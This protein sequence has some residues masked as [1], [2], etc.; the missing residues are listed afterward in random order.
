MAVVA[1]LAG[2][3]LSVALQA[4]WFRARGWQVVAGLL[5]WVT[6]VASALF[7]AWPPDFS[8]PW[9]GP[10]IAAVS[11]GMACA[12][13]FVALRGAREPERVSV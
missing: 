1:A 12:A 6:S 3:A 5:G 7:I 9:L 2:L 13:S 4:P 10:W 11:G 8:S